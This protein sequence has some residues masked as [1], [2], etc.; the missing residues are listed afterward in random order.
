MAI[1]DHHPITFDDFEGLYT[2]GSDLLVPVGHVGEIL[3][4]EWDVDVLKTRRGSREK[5]TRSSN[6]A[7]ILRIFEYHRLGEASRI[8]FLDADG[9]FFDSTNLIDPIYN[10][11]DA[12][13]FSAVNMF[14]RLYISPHNRKE[15]MPGE[16]VYVYDGTTFRPAAGDKPD[17][18]L[19]VKES[20]ISGNVDVGTYVIAVCYETQSGF[21]TKP[22]GHFAYVV[23]EDNKNLRIDVT[24]IPLGP[25]GTVARQLVITKPLIVYDGNLTGYIL[26]LAPGGR[27]GD[28]VTT[29]HELNFYLTEIVVSV[30]YLQDQLEVIPAAL[31]L[32]DFS[33]K[34][35]TWNEDGNNNI[36]RVS[37]QADPE[38][39]SAVDGFLIV[40]P[41]D[42]D[43]LKSCFTFQES[44]YMNKSFR[45]YQTADNGGPA[46][47]WPWIS[48][49]K[50]AG[51]EVFGVAQV[52]DAKGSSLNFVLIASRDGLSLF[53]GVYADPELSWKIRSTWDRI[54]VEE[55]NKTQ[56]LLNPVEKK[57]YVS[58]PLDDSTDTSH[59][60]IG[61]YRR[62]L[63]PENIRWSIWEFATGH[64]AIVLRVEGNPV[65]YYAKE[66]KIYAVVDATNDAGAKIPN[67]FFATG[68]L[69]MRDLLGTFH[70]A[71][72]RFSIEGSGELVVVAETKSGRELSRGTLNLFADSDDSLRQIIDVNAEGIKLR[73]GTDSVDEEFRLV[74]MAVYARLVFL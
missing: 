29:V 22:G 56:V 30:E 40:A 71:E 68:V 34:L 44:L 48:I 14:N 19:V 42:S 55:F 51:S 15:G 18:D 62:G 8:I 61:D 24:G 37:R 12:E 69:L 1:L 5:F 72:V 17:S 43:G 25:V 47:T 67:P 70:F 27:I 50:G 23:T 73:V 20:V 35:I 45:T 59:L 32:A 16:K 4:L 21:I 7:D 74:S 13:D 26:Y 63:D 2:R 46:G 52:I 64:E 31:G 49:D 6:A 3:N 54:N 60:L 11:P 9:N 33:G 39:F 36:A 38:S 10:L 66:N 28:N 53:N 41:Q 57:V 65:L 58:V